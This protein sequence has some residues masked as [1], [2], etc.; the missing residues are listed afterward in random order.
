MMDLTG[1]AYC[2]SPQSELRSAPAICRPIIL[3]AV[4]SAASHIGRMTTSHMHLVPYILNV[5]YLPRI[6]LRCSRML[7][8]AMCCVCFL[9]CCRGLATF[10]RK[11]VVEFQKMLLVALS[12]LGTVSQLYQVRAASNQRIAFSSSNPSLFK[13]FFF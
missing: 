13:G 12:V 8:C 3:I 9:A 4:V 5:P 7:A 11:L 1:E 6:A 10:P 2:R